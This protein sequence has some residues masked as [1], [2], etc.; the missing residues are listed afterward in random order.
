MRLKGKSI[1]VTGGG[2]GFG[3]AMSRRFVA[4]G[5][6]VLVADLN[7]DAAETVARSIGSAAVGCKVDVA[8][9]AEF[10]VMVD[11]ALDA[12]GD[13]DSIVNNAGTSHRNGP[14]LEIDEETF[15]RVYDVNVKSIFHS[16]NC[17]LPHFRKRGGGTILNIGSTA[18]LRPRPG[19]T[20][21]NGSKAAVNLISKSLAVELAPDK[22]RVNCIC[23]VIGA[24][25]LLETF[26]GVPDTP[27]NRARF[28]ATIP[29]GRMSEGEDI[30]SA[31]VYLLSDEANFITGVLLPVDG[32]RTV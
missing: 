12:F 19:L 15:D 20:W 9:G 10:R 27:E 29:L 1:I 23:P 31:A 22:V 24:T 3:A 7:L 17:V 32:G 16:V 26:M 2:S 25:A 4:E 5:A 30:A 28:I 8:K 6:K 11:K 14:I 13:V 21:Y 18:G